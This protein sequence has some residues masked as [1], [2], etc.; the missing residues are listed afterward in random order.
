MYTSLKANISKVLQDNLPAEDKA[1]EL[2]SLAF[3]SVTKDTFCSQRDGIRYLADAIRCGV[4]T[5]LTD[6][7]KEEIL[8]KMDSPNLEEA[9]RQIA[10]QKGIP[11]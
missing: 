6:L 5:P 9:R 8:R 2:A 1:K 4:Q 10:K 11:Q 3:E 7:Y